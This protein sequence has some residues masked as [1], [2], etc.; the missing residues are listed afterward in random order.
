MKYDFIRRHA[1]T[2]SV[3]RLCDALAERIRAIHAAK[4]GRYG[5]LRMLAELVDK[6]ETCCYEFSQ[7]L[8]P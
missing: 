6:R 1:G 5:S 2:F 4:K 7:L 3:R 8:H